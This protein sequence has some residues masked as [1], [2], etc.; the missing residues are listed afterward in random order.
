MSMCISGEYIHHIRYA[1][2]PDSTT[3]IEDEHTQ[4]LT[5]S[6]T[7]AGCPESPRT[8]PVDAPADASQR[9]AP[10]PRPASLPTLRE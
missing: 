1:W 5:P 7:S 3:W 8:A 4:L 9:S 10:L 6:I 2:E